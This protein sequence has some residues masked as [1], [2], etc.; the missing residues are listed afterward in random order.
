MAE[1]DNVRKFLNFLGRAEGADYNVIVGHTAKNPKTFSDFSRH[2]GVVGLTTK[3]GSST[4]AG[5]YQITKQTYDD[6][7]P[8]LGITDF[9]PE[10][11]DK[12]ALAIIQRQGALDDVRAGRFEDAIKKLGGRWASLPSSTYSQ[13]KRS[14]EWAQKELQTPLSSGPGPELQGR[15]TN[16]SGVVPTSSPAQSQLLMADLKKEQENDGVWNTIKNIPTAILYGFQNENNA[17]NFIVEMGAG[18]ADPNFTLTKEKFQAAA[19]GLPEDYKPYLAAAVSDDDLARRV[20]RLN[21][22]VTRQQ[23][24]ANMGAGVAFLGTAAGTLLDVDAVL[25]LFPYIGE[26][27]MARKVSRLSNAVRGGLAAGALNAV[28]EVGFGRFRPTAEETDVYIAGLFGLTIGGAVGGLA[29]PGTV[30]KSAREIIA[31]QKKF[32]N[33]ASKRFSE[34]QR[35]EIEGAGLTLTEE[36]KSI[37]NGQGKQFTEADLTRVGMERTPDGGLVRSKEN[38]PDLGSVDVNPVGYG[39]MRA[40]KETPSLGPNIE[41]ARTAVAKAFGSDVMQQLEASGRVKFLNSQDDLPEGLKD[42]RG[43]NAFYDP[44]TDTT[45]LMADRIND[46]NVRGIIMHDVGVHQGLERIVGTPLYSK[47]IAEVDRLAASGDAVAKRAIA[48]A[49]KSPTKDFLKAEEKLAYYMEAMG[50]NV[51]GVFREFIAQVKAFLI[52]RFGFDIELNE[53]DL[54]AIVQGSVRRVAKDKNFGSYSGNFPYV[55]HGGPVKGIDEFSTKF[56]GTGEGNVNQGWG[57]YTT[58]SKFIGNWYREKESMLR[59]MQ[60]S[61]GG[62]YQIRV[63]DA[64]PEQFLRWDSSSQS[65]QVQAALKQAGIDPSGKQGREIYFD[66]MSRMDG[67]TPLAK[68]KAASQFLDSLGIRGNVY[69][70]GNTRNKAVK[71]DNFVF[72]NERHLDIS[73]RYSV[74]EDVDPDLMP[75]R[76]ANG[77]APEGFWQGPAYENFFNREW[78]PEGVRKFARSIFGSTSGYKDHSVVAPAAMDQKK[79]LVGQWQNQFAKTL[80]P[81][82]QEFLE[83]KRIPFGKRSEAL[84]QWNEDLGDYIRGVPGNYDP[85]VIKVGNEWRKLSKEVVDHINNPGRF[86]G[87]V[88]PGLTQRE[89]IDEATGQKTVTDPLEYNDNYLP[90]IQ[91]IHKQST[92]IAQFGRETVERYIGNMFRAANSKISEELA[93]KLGR[94]YLKSVEDA[95]VNR[96]SELVDNLL[97]GFDRV[98][99]KD[100][101]MRIGGISPQDADRII[102]AMGRPAKGDDVGAISANL[103]RRSII[104]ETYTET[105]VMKDGTTATLSYKD[106]FDTDTVGMIN[107]YFNKQAGAIAL[108]NHTGLYRVQDVRKTIAELVKRNYTSEMTAEQQ[109]KMVKYLEEIVDLTLGRPL[110]EFTTFNKSLQMV[111]DYNILTKAGLFV[112]NQ[113]TELSQLLGSPMW[114]SVLKAVPEMG[115][116]VRNAKTGKVNNEVID[117][118]EN[119]SSGPGTQMLRDNPLT[120]ERIW[121]REKGDTAFNRWLDTGD[122]LLK[123]GVFNLFK[124]TGM[125]PVTMM[126]QRTLAVAFVNHMVDHAVNGKKIGYT[127]ERLAWMGLDAN[128]TKAVMDGIKKYHT[129]KGDTRLGQVDFKQWSQDDPQ[130]FSKFIV[131]YQRESGRVI[132]ENDLASMVPIMGR[133]VGQILFQFMGFPLQAW[134]KGMLF[135]WNHR[136]LATLNTVMWAIGFNALM[137]IARTQMQMA[138]MSQ[139]KAKEF[140]DKRLATE[141]IILNAV[142]RIPQLSVLPNI[143]DTVSPVPLFSGM[144]TS[145]D[146]T[147]FITGNPTLS[148]ISGALNMSKKVVRNAASEEYQT[149][150]KDV[151]KWFQLMPLNNV[152]GVNQILNSVASEYPT[153]E[154]VDN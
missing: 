31:D 23:E 47:M 113:I 30:G 29:K 92:L 135:S 101:L 112:L 147:D 79:A 87:D 20:A 28:T 62:L 75:P 116:M 13:P 42:L 35:K 12:I 86:N 146:M 21:E 14:W 131:A 143:F 63:N 71:S 138:G 7:A 8:K 122:N 57:I 11:Q 9:S 84:E 96:A 121:V 49:E 46:K 103:K 66:L 108:T 67:D 27:A 145:T 43:V 41:L 125:T 99:F 51:Q 72:F 65:R 6:F 100:S 95:K 129:K 80:Q 136:D 25:A 69:T 88:K 105:V 144:R 141:Q 83:T 115:S 60:G 119:L 64:S 50:K 55:W 94:W 109:R 82:I 118:L 117:A 15:L 126:Q 5:R 37:L 39:D 4:A 139:E 34:E 53:K 130:T 1:T 78:V 77:N 52:K 127:P 148:T 152:M 24:M 54:I 48:R 81:A 59:G 102:S 140:A 123:R 2:P 32:S 3:D 98:G 68:A 18:R 90:R 114:R 70:T 44:I 133:S 74:G 137:Y 58:S 85:T 56:V 16:P 142:G 97:R 22:A 104:D 154:L 40:L 106:L 110:E 76:D 111:A 38:I 107:N 151:K 134:N 132:Q 120:P 26:V 61:D 89:I 128:D 10:S 45:F 93:E 91:D 33:W 36:G 124:Y 149:T 19:K 17:Y 153:T 150:E 73:A